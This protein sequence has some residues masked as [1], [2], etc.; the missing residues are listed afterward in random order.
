MY[1]DEVDNDLDDDVRVKLSEEE[2]EIRGFLVH[3]EALSEETTEKFI[4][5]FWNEEP[6]K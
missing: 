6:Y 4:S 3:G 1:V 5:K 2:S